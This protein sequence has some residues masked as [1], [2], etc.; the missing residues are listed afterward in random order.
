MEAIDVKR[1]FDLFCSIY[2]LIVAEPLLLIVAVLIKLES[3]GPA[4][5]KQKR[6][7]INELPPVK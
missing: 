1:A 7:T 4:I 6:P 3:P 5:F 2:G